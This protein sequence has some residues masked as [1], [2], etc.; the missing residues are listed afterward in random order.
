MKW[1]P[2]FGTNSKEE[3]TSWRSGAIAH[4]IVMPQVLPPFVSFCIAAWLEHSPKEF[5]LPNK[6]VV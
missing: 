3:K 5:P 4:F 6:F 2:F 1:D